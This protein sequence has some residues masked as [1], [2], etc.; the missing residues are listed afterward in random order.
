MRHSRLRSTG[1][2]LFVP[3]ATTSILAEKLRV[4]APQVNG[5]FCGWDAFE[6][7]RIEAGV[8]RFGIDVD[9]TNLPPEAG[10]EKEAISYSKG[11]YIG[12]EVI[13]RIRTYGQVAK[14]LCGLRLEGDSDSLPTKGDKILCGDKDCGYI[15][16]AVW[17]PTLKANLA[18]GYVRRQ[19]GA[20]TSLTV[21]TRAG[22]RAARIVPT[23]FI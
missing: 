2:D 21:Q 22:Q 20:E 8:P 10:L 9:E 11:C 15:T 5:R 6:I 3:V 1:F 7:A 18:L 4:L 14:T 19:V 12:Q 17:S 13:A 23:P 16:S